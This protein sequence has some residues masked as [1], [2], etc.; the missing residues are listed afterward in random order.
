MKKYKHL[1]EERFRKAKQVLNIPDISMKIA[2]AVA[3]YSS[4]TLSLIAKADSLPEY[5]KLLHAVMAQTER[6]RQNK[7]KM[8]N[9]ELSLEDQNKADSHKDKAE[10]ALLG[11]ILEVLVGISNT[12]KG[13]EGKLYRE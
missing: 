3:G 8:V 9:P 2:T 1:N 10:S 5:H 12:L 11:E 13:M 6:N 4:A 7:K